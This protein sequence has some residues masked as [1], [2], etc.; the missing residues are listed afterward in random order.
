MP[1]EFSRAPNR[2]RIFVQIASYRD[3]DCQTTINDMFAM[4][5]RPE[6][7][8]VGVVLQVVPDVDQACML[9]E[10]SR[11]DQV[12]IKDFHVRDARGVCWARHETQKLWAG[13]EYTLQID[14]HMRFEPGWDDALLDMLRQCPGRAILTTYPPGFTPPK[15]LVR[16]HFPKPTANKF[17]DNRVL[18]FGSFAYT[19]DDLPA[20]PMLHA[21]LAAGFVFGP[22][23]LIADA[24][25]DPYLYFNG[26]EASL[27]ARLWTH[28]YDLYAPNRAV[29]FHNYE[30]QSAPRHWSDDKD[31]TKISDRS[32]ERFRHLF[33]I[34]RAKDPG[35]IQEIER[36]GFGRAR[37]LSE[38]ER[39]TGISFKNLAISDRARSV[40]FPYR[41][42]A[43]SEAALRE[44]TRLK[45]LP[46]KRMTVG[47]KGPTINVVIG[48]APKLVLETPDLRVYDDF[49]PGSL[50]AG[51]QKWATEQAAQ[52]GNR[53]AAASILTASSLSAAP[54]LER[55]RVVYVGGAARPGVIKHGY[56]SK[57]PLDLLVAKILRTMPDLAGVI[58]EAGKAWNHFTAEYLEGNHA[59]GTPF[60]RQNN[61]VHAGR[62]VFFVPPAW[63]VN[64]GGWLL[65]FDRGAV[66]E[67]PARTRHT[68]HNR[69]HADWLERDG[70]VAL[71]SEAGVSRSI[72]PRP[73][74]MVFLSADLYS[75]MTPAAI[76]EGIPF[77]VGG[78]F[79]R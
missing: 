22:S 74:R 30:R 41:T 64:W 73:N 69:W 10:V 9:N 38:Y 63:N 53:A 58:G 72:V 60:R 21:Y 35:A 36:Y 1:F 77:V 24:P 40:Y 70:D 27:A 28:G 14:S 32:F 31:W 48:H 49:L 78:S 79:A 65:V 44:G 13:E 71:A 47:F 45:S 12:R 61:D 57:T 54:P 37:S 43:E 4:A 15:N 75:S 11:P 3:P 6:R 19:S 5:R 23:S 26:E 42:K 68:T 18:M 2:E 76:P 52:S 59:T 29:I 50:F 7:I 16:N 67:E 20:K 46:V 39:F 33:G 25:Y 62:F 17:D 56:P 8:S 51:V 55:T 34:E 66:R